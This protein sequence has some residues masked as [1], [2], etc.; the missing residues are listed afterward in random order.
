M[1]SASLEKHLNLAL[2]MALSQAHEFV[3]IEHILLALTEEPEARDMLEAC[4]AKI[5]KLRQ[6]LAHFLEHHVPA[7]PESEVRAKDWKPEFTLAFHRLLQSAIIQVQSAAK[8]EV[9]SGNLLVAL[10]NEPES[11]AVYFLENQGVSQFRLIQYISHGSVPEAE[12]L[13]IDEVDEAG[14]SVEGLVP[15]ETEEK[16]KKASP[17]EKF[18]VNLN[19]RARA[20][21]VDPLVGREEVIER[22]IHILSRRS[23]NNPLLVGEP[24]VGKTAIADGLALKIVRGE[25]PPS[26][27]EAEIYA[28]DLGSLLAGTK[29]RG[30]FEDRLKAVVRAIKALPH[31]ILFIDEIHTVVGAGST[32]G[33]SMDAANLLK[34][35]LS[36]RELSCIGSTTYKEFKSHFEKD[37][38]LA[39]RFQKIDVKEPSPQ[40]CLRILKGLKKHYEE[41]HRVT[42][43][44]AAL[45]A[46]VDMSSQYITNKFLPDKAIDVMDEAGAMV[47]LLNPSTQSP[48]KVRVKDVEKIV[49]SMAQIP[50]RTISLDDKSRL[51]NLEANLKR[52]IFGQDKAIQTLVSSIKLARSGLGREHKP[53][54]CY[55]FTGPTG[56]GKTEVCKQLA[57]HLG[58]QF[59]RFD[60]SEY[61]EKHSVSRLVGAPPGYV[62][63]DE[64][65]LLT[66]AVI[67][68]PH[69][70]VLMDEL[71]KAHPDVMNILL[72]VMDS[73]RLTDTNGREVDFRNIVLVMTSNAGAREMARGA[74]G[75][76]PGL[77]EQQSKEAIQRLFAPEFLNRLDALVT[78]ASLPND[79]LLQVVSKFI[80]E[81]QEQL[82][83][84]KVELT[85]TE[86]VRQWLFNTGYDPAYGARPYARTIDEHLKKPLVDEILFGRLEKGG[87]VHV[88]VHAN[89]LNFDFLPA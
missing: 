47:R 42:Y 65:G 24:G 17:L 3:T 23:K 59:L 29:Y 49:A 69:A 41:F 25:V 75:I 31:G 21:K 52:V 88:E 1:L 83:K 30:D 67:K 70:V 27:A 19:A 63:Y 54:G 56:V 74:I 58:I 71:E 16:A 33:G 85:V 53:I 38:A 37:R 60:M 80:I 61:M 72:Q 51:Q 14:Q 66:D 20:G 15:R 34:Q 45:R 68:S 40:D 43:T 6:E 64:G 55:L 28:L 18:C 62:G 50:L 89:K 39:R 44:P 11:H 12:D 79:V 2:D 46:M 86:E 76:D 8:L 73:G 26:L 81:F 5:H 36:S 35:D 10:F 32:S 87:K 77:P 22:A 78:F 4:G 9:S 82:K 57:A 13:Y 7:A 48:P 84:K